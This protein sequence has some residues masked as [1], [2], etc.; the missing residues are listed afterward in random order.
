MEASSGTKGGPSRARWAAPLA[1]PLVTV[2]AGLV[3]AW[4]Q[5]D[6]WVSRATLRVSASPDV[7]QTRPGEGRAILLQRVGGFFASRQVLQPLL[8]APPYSR[9]ASDGYDGERLFGHLRDR[10][11]Y[12]VPNDDTIALSYSHEDPEVARAMCQRIA[13]LY[14]DPPTGSRDQA[15]RVAIVA[16]AS[17]PAEPEGPDRVEIVV[18]FAGAGLLSGLG[19]FVFLLVFGRAPRSGG[20]RQ[21]VSSVAR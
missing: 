3:F 19:L 18:T 14:C 6:L 10:A 15:Y 17:R 21:G 13:E 16:P 2:V 8:E 4:L 9:L 11:G 7:R 5:P 12:D 20:D 1:I